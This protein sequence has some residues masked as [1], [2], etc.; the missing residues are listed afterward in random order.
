MLVG[1]DAGSVG[2]VGDTAGHNPT[3]DVGGRS[4]VAPLAG[5]GLG[6]HFWR[7]DGKNEALGA[8]RLLA[9]AALLL[10]IDAALSAGMFG[11]FFAVSR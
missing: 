9:A 11:I 8:A 3:F 10:R 4:G 5:G 6:G 2:V 7:R 1:V